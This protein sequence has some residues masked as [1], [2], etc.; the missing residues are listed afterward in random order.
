MSRGQR[1]LPPRGTQTT[2]PLSQS[3]KQLVRSGALT[4][5]QATLEITAMQAIAILRFRCYTVP[6]TPRLIKLVIELAGPACPPAY[7]MSPQL[8]SC[9]R[10]E[11]QE[12]PV[13][14]ASAARPQRI[15]LILTRSFLDRCQPRCPH[16]CLVIKIRDQNFRDLPG[17]GL[18]EG[19]GDGGAS[20]ACLGAMAFR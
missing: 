5:G 3:P 13:P 20:S 11:A 14:H 4:G 9:G 6:V 10:S 1:I 16:V 8:Q 17:S 2:S 18:R 15:P 19:G 12:P 7:G